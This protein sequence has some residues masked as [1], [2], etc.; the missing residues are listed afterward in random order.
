MISEET[1]AELDGRKIHYID[2]NNSR[3]PRKGCSHKFI[4]Q[5]FE[6]KRF[7]KTV[8]LDKKDDHDKVD[9]EVI[10]NA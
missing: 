10:F 7:T 8:Y 2:I 3:M 6:P 5:M 1:I 9:L 4:E